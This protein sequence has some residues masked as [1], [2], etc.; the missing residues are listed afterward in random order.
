MKNDIKKIGWLLLLGQLFFQGTVF[1]AA[2]TGILLGLGDKATIIGSCIGSFLANVVV[3][4]IF[5]LVRRKDF[6]RNIEAKV[7]PKIIFGGFTVILMWNLVISLL[8]TLTS[9]K[10][11]IPSSGEEIPALFGLIF[12]AVLPAVME[13]FAFRK[14]IFGLT[15]KHGFWP[16]A[17]L[18]SVVFG[19]MHQNITQ[20]I[21]AFG[22]GIIFCYVYEKTG[23]IWVTMLLHF[24]N[25]ALSVIL[26]HIPVY[27]G[28]GPLIEAGLGI[29]S[30]VVFAVLLIK[31]RKKLPHISVPKEWFINVPMMLYSIICVGM[32][33]CVLVIGANV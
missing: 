28:Y 23:R 10:L 27:E 30:A 26:P 7:T 25:N 32:A 31:N 5:Y 8:D 16:A 24:A 22:M 15:R 14:V 17:I 19:L 13:E 12:I 2:L 29:V 9:N 4:G 18:S 11:S 33:V 3:F 1:L 6:T 21:F 20:G